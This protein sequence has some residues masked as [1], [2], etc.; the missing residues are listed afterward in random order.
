MARRKAISAKLVCKVATL[1]HN[2]AF[3]PSEF[4]QYTGTSGVVQSL[5]RRGILRKVPGGR[6]YPTPR[7][8]KAIDRACNMAHGR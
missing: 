7:G 3:T 1:A 4:S 2:R 6:Y 8:W 5:T